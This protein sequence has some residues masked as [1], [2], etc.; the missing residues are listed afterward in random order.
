M[1]GR[2][3]IAP[4]AL[5]VLWTI[6]KLGEVKIPY[7][8]VVNPELIMII[9]VIVSAYIISLRPFCQSSGKNWFSWHHE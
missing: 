9:F 5:V 3:F 8:K 7:L 2:F 1:H 4:I 6:N